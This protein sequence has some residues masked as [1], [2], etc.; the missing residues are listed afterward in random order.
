M[1]RL[2]YFWKVLGTNILTKLAQIFNDFLGYLEKALFRSKLFWLLFW[3]T[4]GKIG[5]LFY[6]NI[7]PHCLARTCF[8]EIAP[9]HTP[10]YFLT[11]SISWG[12]FSHMCRSLVRELTNCLPF[13]FHFRVTSPSVHEQQFYSLK[14][15]ISFEPFHS[16]KSPR[17]LL[18]LP[19]SK[20]NGEILY[21]DFELKQGLPRIS[22]ASQ[23]WKWRGIDHCQLANSNWKGRIVKYGVVKKSLNEHILFWGLF[24]KSRPLFI[25]FRLSHTTQFKYILIKASLV[26]LGLEPGSAGGRRR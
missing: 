18:L 19:D 11:H 4:L 20:P 21:T 25:Y 14:W 24:E 23:V 16:G 2:G 15:I 26:C 8:L 7:W 9:K 22:T 17:L 5:S 6:F 12:T 10:S 13:G 1:T 3:A